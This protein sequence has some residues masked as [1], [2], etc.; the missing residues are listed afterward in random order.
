MDIGCLRQKCIQHAVAAWLAAAGALCASAE[1]VRNLEMIVVVGEPGEEAYSTS[2][3][4]QAKTWTKLCD[5]AGVN[6]VSI[7]LDTPE[8]EESDR[9]RLLH[10]ISELA[11][12]PGTPLWV[13]LIG[14]GTHDGRETKFNLRGEDITPADLASAISGL[15]QEVVVIHTGPAGG[16]FVKPLSGTNRLII[17]AT[18][19]AD[20]IWATRFGGVFVDAL[21]SPES[22]ADQ[23]HDGQISLLEAWLHTANAVSKSY[24]EDG[25]IATEHSVLDDNGDG[26]PTRSESF[27]GLQLS[28]PPKEGT[29]EG[30]R[31]RQWVLVLGEEEAKLSDAQRKERDALERDLERLKVRQSS[32][33]DETYYRQLEDLLLRIAA[34]YDKGPGVS[35]PLNGKK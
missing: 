7:G 13:V 11:Q 15:R 4:K 19:S 22:G 9:D 24:E 29:P 26:V 3:E 28:D 6:L 2:F 14:H 32:I 5:E 30:L 25:R 18:K 23:D 16:A 21:S 8:T 10:K 34:V 20:E 35:G 12:Q 31:A 33:D 1:T 27:A 17:S